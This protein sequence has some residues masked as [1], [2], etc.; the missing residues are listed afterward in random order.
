MRFMDE[1]L[2]RVAIICMVLSILKVH[3][4]SALLL[5]NILIT[6]GGTE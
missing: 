1:M 4:K 2:F 5:Q 6:I 3:G